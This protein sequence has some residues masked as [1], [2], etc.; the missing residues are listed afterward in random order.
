MKSNDTSSS[1]ARRI[2][3]TIR[4]TACL[5]LAAG[6]AP[7]RADV[8]VAEYSGPG[9]FSCAVE[10]MTDIDQRRSGLPNNGSSHCAPAS[11]MN[12]FAYASNFGF[13]ELLP[14]PGLWSGADRHL[15]MTLRVFQL[16]T[17]MGTSGESGTGNSGIA[18]G[19]G[20]WL[21]ESSM[22]AMPFVSF[23]KA[24]GHWP[25]VDDGALIAS[26]GAIVSYGFGRYDALP[27]PNGVPLL[28]TRAQGHCVTLQR[29]A[30]NNG[31]VLGPREL[32][33]RNPGTPDDGDLAS[34]SPYASVDL[35]TAANIEIARDVDGD[36]EF[37]I[38]PVT[39]MV[40]PPPADGRY[41]VIDGF[42]A[43]YPPGGMSYTGVELA[44]QF[45]NNQLGFVQNAHPVPAIVSPEY[46]ILSVVPHPELHSGL[47]LLA[48]SGGGKLLARVP[49]SGTSGRDYAGT[50]AIYQDIVIPNNASALALGY[51]H[52]VFVVGQEQIVHLGTPGRSAHVVDR[53]P[54]P[55]AL[56]GVRIEA[57]TYNHD[58]H[59]IL[60]I[61]G[62]QHRM[63][64]IDP[65]T[66]K[67][68]ARYILSTPGRMG[69][70]RSLVAWGGP[71]SSR[72]VVAL[73]DGQ[74]V[75]AAYVPQPDSSDYLV[76]RK[77]DGVH[78]VLPGVTDALSVDVDNGGR[79]YVADKR[80]GLLEFTPQGAIGWERAAR[81]LYA[82]F[83]LAGRK[84]AV[85]KSRT[86]IRPELHDTPEWNNI[87]AEGLIPLGPE[88][89]DTVLSR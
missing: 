63:F 49:H 87:P 4:T 3:K 30:A 70:A 69:A 84:F 17:R 74:L 45:S 54:L 71:R 76:W 24:G 51:G 65:T 32:R 58:T 78:L 6:V 40:N 43:L 53:A 41:R 61:S 46:R 60:L 13:P 20:T 7:V 33:H 44:A 68:R 15:E 89:P 75:Q 31:S 38:Y 47:A 22:E 64:A 34:N 82:G 48:H 9:D 14:G 36:G 25:V 88:I 39:S 28:T 67:L 29:T 77:T 19:V 10:F 56:A 35:T 21:A 52:S 80:A 5:I 55:G 50:H 8:T 42:Y 1:F 16:G 66:L 2:R 73:E 57:A 81:P 26:G 12:L 62:T 85:F 72:M 27:G 37:N 86:N 18:N 83:N 23:L 11:V 79:L 59:E